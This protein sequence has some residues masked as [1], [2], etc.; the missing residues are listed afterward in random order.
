MFNCFYFEFRVANSLWSSYRERFMVR[1]MFYITVFYLSRWIKLFNGYL[2]SYCYIWTAFSVEW[3][4]RYDCNFSVTRKE[5]HLRHAYIVHA[6][7][8]VLANVIVVALSA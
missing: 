2:L 5:P 4:T 8:V 6:V 1:S 3:V 7:V